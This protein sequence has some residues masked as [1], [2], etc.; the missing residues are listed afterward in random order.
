VNYVCSDFVFFVKLREQS[1]E[2]CVSDSTALLDAMCNAGEM[3]GAILVLLFAKRISSQLL[4]IKIDCVMLFLLWLFLIPTNSPL[5]F[6]LGMTP[7]LIAVNVF[8]AASDISILSYIQSSFASTTEQ[9]K[10]KSVSPFLAFLNAIIF[11]GQLFI[12]NV[13]FHF[14]ISLRKFIA[15]HSQYI[16]L[17][18]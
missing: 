9:S 12:C 4:W 17:Q 13:V 16:Q 15:H 1:Y 10:K 18:P 2:F 8:Y 6:T 7:V 14:Q 3:I 5:A 11:G